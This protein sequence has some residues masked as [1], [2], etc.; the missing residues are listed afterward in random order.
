MIRFY[1]NLVLIKPLSKFSFN[2]LKLSSS[3][4]NNNQSNQTS[5][6]NSIFNEVDADDF[7]LEVL[8]IDTANS[9]QLLKN[10]I[11]EAVKVHQSRDGDTGSSAVQ[12]AVLTEKIINLT[13]HFAMHK[14]DHHSKRG[15]E[16]S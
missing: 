1:K 9:K 10:K 7:D 8:S 16:V 12:I 15:F 11:N 5:D 6:P 14:K 3:A 2:N 13:R 4:I